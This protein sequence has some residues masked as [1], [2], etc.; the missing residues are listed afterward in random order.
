MPSDDDIAL[1]EKR[2][3]GDKRTETVVYVAGGMGLTRV[4]VAGDQVG[5][6]ELASRDPVRDVAGRDGRLLV[7]TAEDVLVGAGGEFEPADFGP[8]A[9][10]GL[11]SGAPDTG[12][13][14]LAAGPDGEV[15]LLRGDQWEPVGTAGDPRA[16]DGN[17][18]AAGDGV[19]RAGAAGL[20]RLRDDPATDVAASG[21]Y[22]A[23]P[24]GLY[25]LPGRR[26]R[27]GE[28]SVVAA[29]ADSER[30]HAVAGGD[31]FVRR[32]GWD[33]VDLPTDEPVV[34]VAYG[35]SV[36]AVT[37]AGTLLV[38]ADPDQTPD[39]HGGWRSR[40]LGVREVR[41]LAVP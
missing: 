40:A 2:M 22:A 14:P 31:L 33:R 21:P 11:A 28:H 24:D 38:R 3:Y 8:A 16:I 32:D 6:F 36:Y 10:V 9:A 23:C 25:E 20:D 29:D 17:L 27:D 26:L 34:D 30:A 39:G 12:L 15:G 5:R 41:R 19:Y 4:E 18:L 35:E 37:A 7:A 1:D 13:R